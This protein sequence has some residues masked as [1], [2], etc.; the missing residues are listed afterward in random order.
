M[1]KGFKK[2]TPISEALN[3]VLSEIKPLKSEV[4]HVKDCLNRV[5]VDDIVARYDVPMFLELV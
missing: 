4:L 1:K 3:T 5:I 2:L